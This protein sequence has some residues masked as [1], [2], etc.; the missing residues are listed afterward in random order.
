MFYNLLLMTATTLLMRFVGVTFNVYIT[1]KIGSLGIGLFTLVMSVGGFAVTFATSGV[2]LAATRL[3]A[4]AMGKGNELAVRQAM[5]RCMIYS[6]C[7][8]AAASVG[9]LLLSKP[10]ALGILKDAR[11]ILPLRLFS[12]SLPCISLSSAMSG[13]FTA[14]RRVVKSAAA[15]FFEQFVKIIVT[16]YAVGMLA[17]KG[18]EYA[19]VAVIVGGM[20]AEL[21]SFVF[22]FVMYRRDLKK[23]NRR[24]GSGDPALTR[25]MFGIALPIAFTTYV[26]SGLVTV[27]HLLIPRG[28]KKRGS[29]VERALSSY[30]TLHGMVFPIILF[31]QAVLSA[32]AGLLVPEV[33]ECMA[34]GEYE[35][36]ERISS[37][38]IQSAL[39]FGIGVSGIML[40]NSLLLGRA[41]YDSDE[42]AAFIRLLSPL[43]PVMYLDHVVDGLLKG[44]G[45]Q[46]Y[47]MRVNIADAAMSVLLVWA[48][49][50][51][52]GI[53]GYIMIVIAM[54]VVNCSLSVI[55][56]LSRVSVRVEIGKWIAKPLACIIGATS[57]S[58]VIGSLILPGIF[59]YAG[60]AVLSV[61][62]CTLLYYAFL[63]LIG[64][65]SRDDVGWFISAIR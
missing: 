7:F 64:G 1:N 6:L 58:G 23:H 50:P 3:T 17:P 29:S 53:Y 40:S 49:V 33:S 25:R 11:C 19:C 16:V 18:I 28:L 21:S 52:G 13:Y 51:I 47:S 48:F 59:G 30:G 46:L 45:E 34:A 63:R 2:N 36:I 9:L 8:G 44:L 60:D 55:R 22:T 15:Q 20:T 61:S 35:R 38:V 57:L 43:I 12:V 41:I 39:A 4:E 24:T 32:F 56:L 5:R 26:R 54:E 27:E 62:V 31:P 37:R 14:Q 10:I 42:A 65:V